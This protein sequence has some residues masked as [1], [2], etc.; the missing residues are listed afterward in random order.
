MKLEETMAKTKKVVD[1]ELKQFFA[2]KRKEAERIH[3]SVVELVDQV[4]DVTMRG[5]KRM[6]PF[7]CW[8]GYAAVIAASEP[9]SVL[10][11]IPGQARDDIKNVM[12]A[13]ELFQTFALI[14]D[15][16]M[17]DDTERRGGPTVHARVGVSMAIL[18]GDLALAWADEVMWKGSLDYARDDLILLYEK[19]KEEVVYGQ[20]LDI[21]GGSKEKADEFKTAWYS[22]V[23]PLQIGSLLAAALSEV[24]GSPSSILDTWERY[25]VAVGKLFQLRDDVLDGELS[26]DAFAKEAKPLEE[27]ALKALKE[28]TSVN[29]IKQLL[30]DFVQFVQKR[31]S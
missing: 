9:E 21:A 16:I 20:T 19:M 18:A 30:I 25:G 28:L 8:L 23:R 3:P 5:G 24:E 7:L 26:G 15:D 13:L 2:K 6:R 4:A 31:K 11:G 12:L 29:E 17:D 22:V 10:K 27:H 14:H 1:A